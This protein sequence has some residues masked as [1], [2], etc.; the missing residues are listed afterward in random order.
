MEESSLESKVETKKETKEVLKE[1]MK[2]GK[3]EESR[4]IKIEF[5][6]NTIAGIFLIDF[7]TLHSEPPV[8]LNKNFSIMIEKY[9][10]WPKKEDNH[11][12][13]DNVLS[14]NG[15]KI[16]TTDKGT[17]FGMTLKYKKV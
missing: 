13:P 1:E 4:A 8:L 3:K 6:G 17:N 14:M 2:E 11:N 16:H 9:N 5:N 10:A 7:L 12:H 15:S